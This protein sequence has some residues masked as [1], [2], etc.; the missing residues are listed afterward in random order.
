MGKLPSALGT[1]NSVDWIPVNLVAKI[2]VELLFKAG[3]PGD[4][5]GQD[6]QEDMT[7]IQ[8]PIT[9]L[10]TQD[11]PSDVAP[12]E[13]S[14]IRPT[15]NLALEPPPLDCKTSSLTASIPI[16]PTFSKV[17]NIVNPRP[18]PYPSLIPSILSSSHKPLD[19][20]PLH[21]W[22]STLRITAD[23][24]HHAPERLPAL[25]II[26]FIESFLRPEDSTKGRLSTGGAVRWSKTMRCLMPVG[27]EWMRLWMWQ[28]GFGGS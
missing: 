24:D 28:W 9:P 5:I 17:F 25:K 1:M 4:S 16:V 26:D 7:D 27:G 20:V 8:P 3:N 23:D 21:E 15:A 11:P 14:F 19:P 2:L 13:L 18:I 12:N 22:L 6:Y 10:P